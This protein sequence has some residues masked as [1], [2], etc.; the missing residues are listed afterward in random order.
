MPNFNL[1][2]V[3]LLPFSTMLERHVCR[4]ILDSS[5]FLLLTASRLALPRARYFVSPK[6]GYSC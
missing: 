1:H 4:K 6:N 2:A 3:R 5:F